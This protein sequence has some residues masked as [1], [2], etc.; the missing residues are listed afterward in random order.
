MIFSSLLIPPASAHKIETTEDVGATL[1][2]EPADTPRAGETALTWFALTRKGGKI[3]PLKECD[4]QLAVYSEPREPASTPISEPNLEP[5]S[6]ERYQGIP[7]ANITF[8]KPGAYQLELTGKP[9]ND[10]SFKPFEL[11]FDVTVAAGTKKSATNQQEITEKKES[12]EIQNVSENQTQE[13]GF[14]LPFWATSLIALVIL[15]GIFAFIRRG[16][17]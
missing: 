10:D 5:V 8:P 16:K 11:K 12:Q 17:G 13:Q 9:A 4:C 15:G 14:S 7:G 2:I 3:I 6:A 1:H